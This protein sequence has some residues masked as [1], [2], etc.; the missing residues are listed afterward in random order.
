MNDD[1]FEIN[2]NN[3]KNHSDITNKR[4]D[5][6]EWKDFLSNLSQNVEC[7]PEIS[8]LMEEISSLIEKTKRL[9]VPEVLKPEDSN[10]IDIAIHGYFIQ[11]LSPNTIEKH[12]R[13]KRF[14]ERHKISVDFYPPEYSN[15]TR[16]M[17]FREMQGAGFYA[18]KHEKQAIMMFANAFDIADK[19]KKYKLPREPDRNAIYDVP[20][21]YIVSKFS[22]FQYFPNIKCYNNKLF[23]TLHFH[24]WM[25]GYRA[26]SE[27][28]IMK[29]DNVQIDKQGNGYISITQPKRH[30][31]VRKV[32]LPKSILS[33][34]V[35]KSFKNY[36]DNIRP[37]VENQYSKDYL[38]LQEN[39]KPFTIRHL[40]HCLSK[41]GKMIY[42][43]YHPYMARHWC[44]IAKLTQTKVESGYFDYYYVN[45][46]MGHKDINTTMQYVA[47]ASDYYNVYP[48]NWYNHALKQYHGGK[49]DFPNRRENRLL[50]GKL[51]PVKSSGLEEVFEKL[52]KCIFQTEFDFKGCWEFQPSSLNLFF[53]LFRLIFLTKRGVYV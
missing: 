13:Y 5:S 30:G 43:D 26:P 41:T 3:S 37:K 28:A 49:R 33:S 45:R 40:G 19:F 9:D 20:Y 7:Q 25:V 18:L 46:W 50:L 15:F 10:D 6:Q 4:G 2:F 34:R 24:N 12:L 35:N 11:R 22:T 38:Y 27:I 48:K 17:R 36:I 31:A 32:I 39:G 23:Q 8:E 16:H 44:S 1:T 47:P 53:F 51:S 21:P 29:V 14:M 42:P 52:R